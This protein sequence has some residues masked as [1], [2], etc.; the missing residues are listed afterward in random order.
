MGIK[1]LVLALILAPIIYQPGLGSP[2]RNRGTTFE[3]EGGP[4]TTT[5]R[6]TATRGRQPA[7]SR[8]ADY[9]HALAARLYDQKKYA[10]AEVAYK[11]A[12]S[13][14]PNEAKYYNDIGNARYHQKKYAEAEAAFRKAIDIDPNNANYHDGLG[15]ALEFQ[16]MYAEAEGAFRKA[17]TINPNEETYHNDLGYALENQARYAEAESA[18]REGLR[19]NPNSP[20]ILN[21][22]GYNLIQRNERLTEALEMIQRAVNAEPYNAA[23]LDSL[24]WAYFKL[25]RFKEAERYL[26]QSVQRD[27]RSSETYEHLGDLYNKTHKSSLALRA[28]RR[29]LSLAPS[30]ERA[31][32]LRAKISGMTGSNKRM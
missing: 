31:G 15:L 9:Y 2:Q 3:P 20:I 17:I 12:I 1:S 25:D 32:R 23:Y 21:N 30:A 13:I 24:G 11:K 8:G 18:Y 27:D 10:E 28:W 22:L 6:S 14:N 5:K 19:L 29:S 26:S 7:Q 16:G 4:K